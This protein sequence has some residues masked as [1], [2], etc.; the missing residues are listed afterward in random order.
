MQDLHCATCGKPLRTMPAYRDG[1]DPKDD[2]VYC[3]D[4]ALAIIDGYYRSQTSDEDILGYYNFE[5]V[6]EECTR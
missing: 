5:E 3:A 4:C 1:N 2:N 6:E